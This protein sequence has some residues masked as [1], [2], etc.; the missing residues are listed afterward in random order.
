MH[1]KEDNQMGLSQRI[2]SFQFFKTK[3]E[4]LKQ[5]KMAATA[6]NAEEFAQS[7]ILEM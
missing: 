3:Y 2:T 7:K 4:W 5:K 1:A 6:A